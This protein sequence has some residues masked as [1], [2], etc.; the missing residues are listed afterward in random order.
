MKLQQ[1]IIINVFIRWT[2]DDDMGNKYHQ[3][4]LINS[5]VIDIQTS[6]IIFLTITMNVVSILCVPVLV[7]V[8]LSFVKI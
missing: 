3:N 7:Y 8:C 2:P 4:T 1:M 6:E 5:K